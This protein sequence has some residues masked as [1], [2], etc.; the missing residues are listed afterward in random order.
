MKNRWIQDSL[1][2]LKL[3]PIDGKTSVQKIAA[4]L[5]QAQKAKHEGLRKHE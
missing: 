5:L 2:R 3:L 4:A 1:F